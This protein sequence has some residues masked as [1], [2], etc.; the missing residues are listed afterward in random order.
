M[1]KIATPAESFNPTRRSLIA[2]LAATPV[3]LGAKVTEA[4]KTG[5]IEER[6]YSYRA[7]NKIICDAA[8]G[9]GNDIGETELDWC[10]EPLNE[11]MEIAPDN[12]RE[13]AALVRLMLLDDE[14]M[15]GDLRQEWLMKRANAIL[16]NAA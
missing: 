6:L 11:A 13:M 12:L 4:A 15:A 1:T 9:T 7:R 10:D 14:F 8:A 2:G 5:P 3:A 16:E